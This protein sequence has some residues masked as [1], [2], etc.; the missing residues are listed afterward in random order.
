MIPIWE[1]IINKELIDLKIFKAEMVTRKHPL[2]GKYADFVVLNS[3][4]WANVIPITNDGNILLIEQFRQGTNSVTIEIPGGLIEKNEEPTIA[5][6]REC[7]EETGYTSKKEL[8]LLGVSLPNPA[9]LNNKCFTF[10]WFDVE[11]THLQNFDE[12]EEINVIPTPIGEIKKMI[13][14][15]K[16]NHSIITTAF[17]YFFLKYGL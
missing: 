4:N 11:K 15:G 9:F 2:S 8:E 12:N 3:S 7:I 17:F 13:Q 10:A 6:R 5:A 16:I 1:T 14:S